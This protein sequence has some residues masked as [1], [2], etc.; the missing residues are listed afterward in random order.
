MAGHCES[1]SAPLSRVSDSYVIGA[2]DDVS[3]AEACDRLWRILL[4][5][6]LLAGVG[7]RDSIDF[8]RIDGGVDDG[9]ALGITEP[10]FLPV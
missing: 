5:N 2:P 9:R 6:S 4:K 1:A 8:V 3:L 7:K 10:V